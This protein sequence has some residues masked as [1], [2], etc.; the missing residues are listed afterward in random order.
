MTEPNSIRHAAKQLQS[1]VAAKPNARAWVGIDGFVD[2]ITRAVDVRYGPE[3]FDDIKTIPQ[4]AARIAAAAG[5][6]TNIELVTEQIKLGGNGPLMAQALGRLGTRVQYVGAIGWPEIEP[7][8][9]DLERYGPITSI[10][11]PGVTIATEFED[12]KIMHGRMEGLKQVTYANIVERLGGESALD[13]SLRGA[14]LLSL[15]NWTMVSYM[16]GVMEGI[17]SRFGL[18]GKDAPRFAFFDL[19]DPQKRTPEDLRD[20]LKAIASFAS[21]QTTA[22]L[23]LNERESELVCDAIGVSWDGNSG[24]E[25]IA[26]ARRIVE[27]IGVSEVVIHPTRR[28]SAFG[29]AGSGTIEGPY[30]PAPKLTTGAGDHF[31]GGYA[32]ARMRGLPPAESLV[33]GKAVSGFYVREGRGPSVPEVELFCDRWAGGTLDPWQ[34]V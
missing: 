29:A 18:L 23:G 19:C 1:A 32:F 17:D 12:G 30:C 24:S 3:H 2:H 6:S 25:L 9:R 20:G 33:I 11:P 7:C 28:A 15:V 14:D 22:I 16:N 27:T 26:R 4:Y 8:F 31:N 10:A 13:E 5:K 34:G 21:T